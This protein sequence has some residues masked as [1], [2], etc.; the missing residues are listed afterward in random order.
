M[1]PC[2]LS[3]ATGTAAEAICRS[4]VTRASK[5]APLQVDRPVQ[6]HARHADGHDQRVD[7]ADR[8]ARHLPRHRRQPAA[9]GQHQPTCCGCSWATWWSPRCWWSASGR[10]GDMFGRV[11]MYNLGFAVFAAVLGPAV[12][13]PGCTARPRAWWLIGMR[14][15]Q[16]VGGAMLMANS[17]AILTDAF[18]ANERGHGA[19]HQPGGRHRRL[20]HRAGARRRAR[21]DR[22]APGVPGLG[23]VRRV[24]HRLVLPQ[25]ARSSASA[26]PAKIDWLGNIT[27]ARR[28]DRGPGRHHLRHPALRRPHHGLDQPAG[29]DR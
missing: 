17:S 9:A 23:A 11:R 15:L 1:P 10:L 5:R 24:R 18:P 7:H 27:F 29:A 2:H 14:V 21:P 16:G 19:G 13:R 28:P 25:A 3:R 6:H 26:G 20:V 4:A 12:G 22:L 8:A